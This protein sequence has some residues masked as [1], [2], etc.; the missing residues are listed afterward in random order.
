MYRV[1]LAK[2]N[3][4][5]DAKHPFPYHFSDVKKRASSVHTQESTQENI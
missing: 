4:H 1:L 3:T 5:Q 2:C